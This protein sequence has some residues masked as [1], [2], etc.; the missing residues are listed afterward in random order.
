M[1]TVMAGQDMLYFFDLARSAVKR[2]PTVL[3]WIRSWTGTEDLEPLA[4][5]GWYEEGHGITGRSLN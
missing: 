4:P 1:E 3:D 2:H 5:D